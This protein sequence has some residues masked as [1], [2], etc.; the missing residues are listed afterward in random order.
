[1]LSP[2][3]LVDT[4]MVWIA[5]SFDIAVSSRFG[6]TAPAL[7]SAVVDL[8]SDT[9]SYPT[10]RTTDARS[11]TSR[12]AVASMAM[13]QSLNATCGFAAPRQ[14]MTQA[15]LA[16]SWHPIFQTFGS[17]EDLVLSTDRHLYFFLGMSFL[18]TRFTNA[19]YSL[20]A[21]TRMHTLVRIA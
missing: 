21:T 1:M 20:W 17:F 13:M 19:L 16:L 5:L 15:T 7:L 12:L 8:G 11:M 10:V 2:A 18:A 14:K 4:S 6:L 9:E 3:F